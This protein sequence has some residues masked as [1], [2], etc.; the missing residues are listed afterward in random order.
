MPKQYL[1][2]T[3]TA[4]VNYVEKQALK[5]MARDN[6]ITLSAL[7]RNLLIQAVSPGSK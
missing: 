5:R 3:V 2:H 6:G 7:I 1:N 4:S